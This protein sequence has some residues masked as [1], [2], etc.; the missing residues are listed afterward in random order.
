[1]NKMEPG[2]RVGAYEVGELL[3]LG[4][5]GRVYKGHHHALDRQVAIKVLNLLGNGDPLAS[6]RFHQEAK[7]IAHLHHPH[8]VTVY[9]FGDVDGI[10]YMIV[11]YIEGG[12][13]ASRLGTAAQH[14]NEDEAMRLLR[15][16]ASALDYAHKRGIVHRDVK[17]ANIL[18]S[19]ENGAVLAD[20]GLAKMIDES[21]LHSITGM[22]SGTPAYI[23]PEQVSGDKMGPAADVY[24]LGIVAYQM[25]TGRVPFNDDGVMKLLYAHVNRQPP[26]PT[27]F[28]PDLGHAV[29]DV[30]ARAL[31]KD[32]ADRWPTCTA[33]ID[34]L[35]AALRRS[36]TRPVPVL[37]PRALPRGR[38][39]AVLL[40]VSL[41]PLALSWPGD[42]LAL[43]AGSPGRS[44]LAGAEFSG[45]LI[46]TGSQPPRSIGPAG[47]GSVSGGTGEPRQ[48]DAAGA[49]SGS[50]GTPQPTPLD[51]GSG[52]G[53]APAPAPSNSQPPVMGPQPSP[54]PPPPPPSPS[55]R[56]SPNPVHMN[57][58]D[59][60]VT[61][62]NYQAGRQ[63]T[64]T[65]SQGANSQILTDGFPVAGNGTFTFTDSVSNGFRPGPATLTV[66]YQGGSGCHSQ[67]ITLTP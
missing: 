7:A 32:P 16:V 66:C 3:G 41:L 43:G 14:P 11:E 64:I 10:P 9:D 19:P 2:T 29:D 1:M 49:A 8:I 23:A 45:G 37:R 63:V 17:P 33:F 44:A 38:R 30:F 62:S 50:S 6:S 67:T 54:T 15:D 65:I 20:F 57:R 24:S 52:S 56:S 60:T 47:S 4:G 12:S 55:F 51:S 40:A 21:S 35:D 5:A 59:I 42:G 13:L 22:T 26:A 46:G 34:A 48:S 36:T 27:L 28:R 39:L 58:D 31:A 25:L 61:G 53:P 18:L